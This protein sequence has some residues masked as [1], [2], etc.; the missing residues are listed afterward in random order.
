MKGQKTRILVTYDDATRVR[1]R[2]S[3]AEP[4]SLIG[5]IANR[6]RLGLGRYFVSSEK[7]GLYPLPPKGADLVITPRLAEHGSSSFWDVF[8]EAIRTNAGYK[9]EVIRQ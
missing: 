7:T 8:A 3:D 9:T 2:F 5:E 6:L 4:I 1:C